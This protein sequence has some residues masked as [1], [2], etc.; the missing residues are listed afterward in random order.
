MSRGNRWSDSRLAEFLGIWEIVGNWDQ[1]R[2]VGEAD[3]TIVKRHLENRSPDNDREKDELCSH[4]G[5]FWKESWKDLLNGLWTNW[6]IQSSCNSK[7]V[8]INE[9]KGV[10][11]P[12]WRSNNK[13]IGIKCEV[14]NGLQIPKWSCQLVSGYKNPEFKLM[15]NNLGVIWL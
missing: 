9:E 12:C 10:R 6:R 14:W 7:M 1:R 11:E 2:K 3:E 13:N 15:T 4:S 5:T 8:A